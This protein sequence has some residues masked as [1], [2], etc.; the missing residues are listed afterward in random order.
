MVENGLSKKTI[1]RS[2]KRPCKANQN[3]KE[4]QGGCEVPNK[5]CSSKRPPTSECKSVQ[6]SEVFKNQ[7]PLNVKLVLHDKELVKTE[8]FEKKSLQGNGPLKMNKMKGRLP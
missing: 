6:P 7:E 2:M 3:T 1:K 4:D 5:V 8:A